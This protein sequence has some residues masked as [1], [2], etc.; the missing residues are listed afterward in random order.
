MDGALGRREPA[1]A[2]RLAGEL[3]ARTVAEDYR[4]TDGVA[5][6]QSGFAELTG[7]KPW[8]FSGKQVDPYTQEHIDLQNAII[9]DIALNEAEQ[10]R[11]RS[12]GFCRRWRWRWRWRGVAG[13]KKG[14]D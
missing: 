9:K 12:T 11:P 5:R 10:R 2:Q 3:Y 13:H 4:G 14:P 6:M 1:D 8:K 7:A